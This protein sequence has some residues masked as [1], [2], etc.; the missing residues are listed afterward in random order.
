M[1]KG[2]FWKLCRKL[3]KRKF[4]SAA[5]RCDK[6]EIVGHGTIRPQGNISRVLENRHAIKNNDKSNPIVQGA[7]FLS[8]WGGIS[9]PER[10]IA[11]MKS[12]LL[13][14]NE[15]W[16]GMVG[17][18]AAALDEIGVL[19]ECDVEVKTLH[20]GHVKLSNGKTIETDVIILACGL[21][22]SRQLLL[23]LD[24]LTARETFKQSSKVSASIIEIGLD[25][26]SLRGKHAII[27]PL[28]QSAI[29][30]YIG[31]QSRLS[32]RGSHLSAITVGGL[33]GEPG[34]IKFDSA[35]D[36]LQHLEKFLDTHA[37]GWKKHI[38]T[39]LKQEKI[40]IHE[41]GN[42]RIDSFAFTQSGILLAGAWVES[43][44]ILADGAVLSGKIAGQNIARAHH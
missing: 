8:D 30:D 9:A 19:I 24:D 11:L 10:L 31:I 2:P 21:S 16:I 6:I 18:L 12:K 40:T 28:N 13:V 42:P 38:I 15:G 29:I 23:H 3:S 32:T 39:E 26:Q 33:K 35:G 17:R 43:E 37:S 34:E 14:S 27:D 5:I 1:K 20:D 7:T 25:A 36:R 44:H 22:K 41:G 4:S